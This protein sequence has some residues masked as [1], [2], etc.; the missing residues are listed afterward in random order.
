MSERKAFNIGSRM[1]RG[2]PEFVEGSE[3]VGGGERSDAGASGVDTGAD[4]PTGKKRAM[5]PGRSDGLIDFP[6]DF[7]VLT[8]WA[9]SLS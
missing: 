3:L 1:R 9:V 6:Y 2:S 4:V 5:P 8:G 7:G